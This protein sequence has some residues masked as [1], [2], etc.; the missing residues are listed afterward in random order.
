MWMRLMRW[1][2]C[3][4]IIDISIVVFV[5]TVNGFV[6]VLFFSLRVWG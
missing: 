3:S 2:S 1:W 5:V 6:I 4:E